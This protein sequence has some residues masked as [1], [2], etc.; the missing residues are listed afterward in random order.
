VYR[1]RIKSRGHRTLLPQP[2]VGGLGLVMLTVRGTSRTRS[3]SLYT[4]R[5]NCR[6]LTFSPVKS[7]IHLFFSDSDRR[8]CSVASIPLPSLSC[9]AASIAVV[10]ASSAPRYDSYHLSTSRFPSLSLFRFPPPSF[11]PP[12]WPSDCLQPPQPMTTRR[13]LTH[14]HRRANRPPCQTRG[15]GAVYIA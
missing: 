11:I 3:L 14:L 5:K 10:G 1:L 8:A 15:Y 12:S 7:I 4:K 9:C 2:V 13:H 6:S